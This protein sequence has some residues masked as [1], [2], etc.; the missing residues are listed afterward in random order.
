MIADQVCKRLL[1]TSY[2]RE[3]VEPMKSFDD[4]SSVSEK[5]CSNTARELS[6]V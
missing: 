4:L 6:K 1:E 3:D 5:E 2:I